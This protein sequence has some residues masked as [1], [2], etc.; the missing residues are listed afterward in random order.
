LLHPLSPRGKL[1]YQGLQGLAATNVLLDA[2]QTHSP[3][4]LRDCLYRVA[5]DE[6]QRDTLQTTAKALPELSTWLNPADLTDTLGLTHDTDT[7]LGALK[8]HN[9]CKVVHVPSY[10]DGLWAACQSIG[11]GTV[12]WR[13]DEGCAEYS[14]EEW[15]PQVSCFDI[16]VLAAGAGIF[17][18]AVLL[19]NSTNLPIQLV[20]GQS[21]EMTMPSSEEALPNA[22]LSGKYV[23][24]LPEPNRVLIGATHEFKADA[25]SGKEVVEELKDRSYA[26]APSVW[27]YGLVDRITSGYRVQ[28]QRGPRGRLPIIGKLKDFG[29]HS[30]AWIFTGLSSRGLLYHGLYGE[31]LAKMILEEEDDLENQLAADWWQ[32]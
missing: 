1:V 22:L 12:E 27:D 8:L 24:P 30:N 25:L 28:S 4:I 32:K 15:K 7:M 17:Q 23:S 5:L 14:L 10:L 13:G 2:A 20:R 26:L 31:V 19:G 11:T 21:V 29:C 6:K 3:C 9:G 18:S 16:V